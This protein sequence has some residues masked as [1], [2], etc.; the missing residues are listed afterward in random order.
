M[1]VLRPGLPAFRC[2]A[3][4]RPGHACRGGKRL[5]RTWRKNHAR[6]PQRR[7]GPRAVP[8]GQANAPGLQLCP[9]SSFG[10][11]EFHRVSGCS[12]VG[13]RLAGSQVT[14]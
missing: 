13:G 2:C 3:V 8:S 12:R 4:L 14:G 1:H 5:K 11:D 10:P 9:S 6:F 7:C